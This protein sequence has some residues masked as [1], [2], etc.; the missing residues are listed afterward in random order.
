MKF[1]LYH[2]GLASAILRAVFVLWFYA[3]ETECRPA[4]PQR[5]DRVK[6]LSFSLGQSS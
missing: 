6:N 1:C 4:T 2:A 5:F 3:D